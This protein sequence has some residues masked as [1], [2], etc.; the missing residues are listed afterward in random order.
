MS[1]QKHLPV[2]QT[3]L[4]FASPSFALKIPV[5]STYISS[6]GKFFSGKPLK[7]PFRRKGTAQLLP[8]FQAFVS[9]SK[10]SI[11]RSTNDM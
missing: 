5:F 11:Q 4:S 6:F 1:V 9:L 2:L 7:L 10:L 8:L 3:I